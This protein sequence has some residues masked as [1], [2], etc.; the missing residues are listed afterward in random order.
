MKSRR[1]SFSFLLALT[2]FLIFVAILCGA[3]LTTAKG[4]APEGA[5]KQNIENA[6]GL[7]NQMADELDSLADQGEAAG[8]DRDQV[9][10]VREDAKGWRD[11]A[12]NI[13]QL[14]R[15][16]KITIDPTVENERGNPKAITEGDRIR[17]RP[18]VTGGNVEWKIK[19]TTGE[20]GL[21]KELAAVLVHEK[22]H[23]MRHREWGA[24]K[25]WVMKKSP[26]ARISGVMGG[27]PHEWFP[28]DVEVDFLWHIHEWLRRTGAKD[29][30]ERQAEVKTEIRD[31]LEEMGKT[32]AGGRDNKKAWESLFEE[33]GFQLAF[34]PPPEPSGSTPS[35]AEV[36]TAWGLHTTTFHT[37]EGKIKV[38]LPDDLTA[39]DSLSGTVIVE[40][41]GKNEE[42]VARNQDE[43]NGYVVEI[44]KQETRVADRS[45]KRKIPWMVI[46][47][48]TSIILKDKNHKELARGDVPCL[49]PKGESENVSMELSRLI[50]AY[51]YHYTIGKENIETPPQGPGR[52]T[53]PAYSPPFR[54]PEIGQA[55]R[56]VQISG[57]FDGDFTNSAVRIGGEEARLLA[58]SPRKVVARIPARVT[59]TTEIE[60]KEGNLSA[61]GRFR[62]VGIRLTSPKTLLHRDEQATLSIKLLGLQG[63]NKQ[64]RVRLE[65]KTPEIVRIEGGNVQDFTL[66]PPLDLV[67]VKIRDLLKLTGINPGRFVVTALILPPVFPTLS[68]HSLKEG[69]GAAEMRD[70]LN[71]IIDANEQE[72]KKLDE[73]N[74]G[75]KM[76]K[77]LL[78]EVNGELNAAKLSLPT[79]PG[80]VA[81]LDEAKKMAD[82]ALDKLDFLATA[83]ALVTTAFGNPLSKILSAIRA[84]RTIVKAMGKEEKDKEKREKLKKKLQE[85]DNLEKDAEKAEN[86]GDKKKKDKMEKEI[87]AKL[88][89]IGETFKE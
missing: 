25:E 8:A 63:Y 15:E 56:P 45:M 28:Y 19:G 66:D 34:A 22:A 75:E 13:S 86:E 65:N 58:E 80:S 50:A 72:M 5:Q 44:E 74:R 78:T 39:G 10:L 55:G 41:E 47:G 4:A 37:P 87:K 62:S 1:Q 59:G 81:G 53:L 17:L 77:D 79:R 7:I 89:E 3:S 54:L 69:L 71:A 12:A 31:A 36:E 14:L 24:F 27:Q 42:E 21:L 82:L 35:T 85:L 52:G 18:Q 61:K 29:L 38:N 60:V 33:V 2:L 40:P 51:G 67:E 88:K 73:T 83:G 6:I 76:R 46:S 64:V 49:S 68:W 26:Q 43:L 32:G 57:R 30:A 23:V 84:V 20:F 9:K 16:G 11:L 48:V 70:L